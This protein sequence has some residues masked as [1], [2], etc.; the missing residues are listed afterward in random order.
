MFT[1]LFKVI[2]WVYTSS[3]YSKVF[4]FSL[5]LEDK[6]PEVGEDDKDN[7]FPV[8]IWL[9]LKQPPDRRSSDYLANYNNDLNKK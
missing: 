3:F 6:V 5:Y 9:L 1:E 4:W 8:K 2:T 7:L